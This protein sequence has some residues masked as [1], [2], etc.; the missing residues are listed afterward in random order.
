MV[1]PAQYTVI[2]AV[3][4]ARR[5]VV[6]AYQTVYCPKEKSPTDDL[7]GRQFVGTA[8]ALPVLIGWLN[9]P[10]VVPKPIRLNGR[11]RAVR[12]YVPP[13]KFRTLQLV[14]HLQPPQL[15]VVQKVVEP[16]LRH[17]RQPLVLRL[18]AVQF[19]VVLF[20]GVR[21]AVRA[22]TRCKK[23]KA[24]LVY[25]V[26]VFAARVVLRP[27][28][29]VLF[30]EGTPSDFWR[31]DGNVLVGAAR[32]RLPPPLPFVFPH[33]L[34]ERVVLDGRALPHRVVVAV[35]RC[36]LKRL[37]AQYAVVVPLVAVLLLSVRSV[38]V[39]P[40]PL[41]QVKVRRTPA[42]RVFRVAVPF[43]F[44]VLPPP[45]VGRQRL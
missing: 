28:L 39:V 1:R 16:P 35:A 40:M 18:V 14:R 10:L 32:H 33:G 12:A 7:D 44:V 3:A 38:R 15:V 4:S 45:L 11:L 31:F 2:I 25:R 24:R 8:V 27:L 5:T 13:Q 29:V 30:S 20:V 43:P 23:V 21:L 37:V 19:L 36:K 26:A 6:T 41:A 9:A 22:A 42:R 17:K 34:F